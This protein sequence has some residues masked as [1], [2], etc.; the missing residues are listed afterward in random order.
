MYQ[1]EIY[2]LPELKDV[3]ADDDVMWV[4]DTDAVVDKKISYANLTKDL[5]ERLTALEK[6]SDGIMEQI[7]VY[8]ALIGSLQDMAISSGTPNYQ[9][10]TF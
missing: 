1:K 8:H 6:N 3:P 7:G 10:V 2:Q 5:N 4:R 9:L